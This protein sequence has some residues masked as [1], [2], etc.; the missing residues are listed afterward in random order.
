[1]ILD[2]E[3]IVIKDESGKNHL[4][5]EVNWNP[6]DEKTNKCQ[7]IRLTYP[8]GKTAFIEREKLMSFIFAIGTATQQK[9]LIPQT[10]HRVKWYETVLSVKATKNIKKGEQIT[11]PIKITLPATEEE[12]IGKKKFGGSSLVKPPPKLLR[13]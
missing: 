4:I 1:M 11:F 7:I 9:D 10:L 3:K 2:Y 5:A 12:I 13:A 8:D 6:E